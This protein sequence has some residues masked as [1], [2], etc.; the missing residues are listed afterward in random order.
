MTFS[1][2]ILRESTNST[3]KTISM[4]VRKE[5]RSSGETIVR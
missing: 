5:T 2:M 4:M 3:G 1:M